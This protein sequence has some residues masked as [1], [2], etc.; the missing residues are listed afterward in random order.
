[1]TEDDL[2]RKLEAIEALFAGA[3]TDGERI[4]AAEARRRIQ[5]RL[6][7]LGRREPP[8]EYKFSL[9]DSWSRRLFVALL[10]RYE[11]RPYRYRRQ[12]HT[13][14]MARVSK[15]FVDQVL[16]PEFVELDRALRQHL[17]QVTERIIARAVHENREEAEEVQEENGEPLRLPGGDDTGDRVPR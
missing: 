3:K 11:I 12:R 6:R 1:V 7:D 8:R 10:R 13:T 9:G 17:E 15:P 5:T 14:V 16:W 2:I 4:A